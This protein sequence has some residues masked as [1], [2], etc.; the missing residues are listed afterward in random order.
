MSDEYKVLAVLGASDEDVMAYTDSAAAAASALA[1]ADPRC[2]QIGHRLLL[3]AAAAELSPPGDEWL[4]C[5]PE[6]CVCS[7]TRVARLS[8]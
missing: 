6:G 3:P 8:P 2:R 5:G 1:T 7:S 4:D